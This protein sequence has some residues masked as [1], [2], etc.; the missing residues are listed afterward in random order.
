SHQMLRAGNPKFDRLGARRDEEVAALE[1][2][3]IDAH[4]VSVSEPGTTVEG[5]DAL[6]G[7]VVLT[8][9]R[10]RIGERA[11]EGDQ[12]RPVDP[13][14]TGHA[15]AAH[16][17]HAVQRLGTG[18]QH[19]LRIAAPQRTGAAEWSEIDDRYA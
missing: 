12:L 11:L 18:D 2:R 17:P 16:A 13:D 1:C 9:M 10:N 7:V 15:A 3:A 5:V 19:L 6:L 4:H 8:L 14:I